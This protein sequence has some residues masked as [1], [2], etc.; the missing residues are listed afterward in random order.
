MDEVPQ[1]LVPVVD[2]DVCPPSWGALALRRNLNEFM[3]RMEEK[4]GVRPIIYTGIFF[5]NTYLAGHYDD[6][7]LFLARYGSETPIPVDG[8]DWLLWQF[9][10]SGRVDGIR[11]NVD[12]DYLNEAYSLDDLLLQPSHKPAPIHRG[13]PTHHPNAVPIDAGLS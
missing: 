4:L 9:S 2:V 6:Y 12:M 3:A 11:G 13:H 1:D 10:S 7:P 5:Y 8:R